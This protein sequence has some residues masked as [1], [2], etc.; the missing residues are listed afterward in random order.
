MPSSLAVVRTAWMR[1]AWS[2]TLPCEALRRK[3]FAPASRSCFNM[4][5]PS[6]AGPSVATILVLIIGIPYFHCPKEYG[7]AVDRPF[8]LQL[9]GVISGAGLHRQFLLFLLGGEVNVPVK[10]RFAAWIGRISDVVQV[11]E[12]L[13]DIRENLVEVVKSAHRIE[14]PACFFGELLQDLL[15]VRSL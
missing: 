6:V 12:F 8:S 15:A 9:S 10:P 4:P 5:G 14:G 3:M 2:S 1:A 13:L 11:A 7:Q